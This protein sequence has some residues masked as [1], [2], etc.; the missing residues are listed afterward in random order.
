MRLKL[1]TFSTNLCTMGK[2]YAEDGELICSTFE[3]PDRKNQVNISCIPDGEYILKMV[4]SPKYGPVYKVH[5]VAN[6]TNILILTL[7][8]CIFIH[9]IIR[10]TAIKI[11]SANHKMFAR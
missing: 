9:S 2:L 5:D 10:T 6:R 1:I 8:L 3:L 7:R 4:V 11:N